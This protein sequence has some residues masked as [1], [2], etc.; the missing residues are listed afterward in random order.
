MVYLALG[1]ADCVEG[2]RRRGEATTRASPLD[3]SPRT[4]SVG[5]QLGSSVLSKPFNSRVQVQAVPIGIQDQLADPKFELP[6]SGSQSM[7]P[8]RRHA[9]T[10][11]RSASASSRSPSI[12][13]GARRRSL[14]VSPTA[15]LARVTLVSLAGLSEGIAAGPARRVGTDSPWSGCG[16]DWQRPQCGR[17]D[18]TCDRVTDRGR[19]EGRDRPQA[20]T[21]RP[22]QRR[23]SG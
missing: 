3:T 11:S 12:R 8:E 2:V 23:C 16:T 22:R 20:A 5:I 1:S 7:S 4:T 14:I 13:T 17:A 18:V 19:S 15:S 6:G 10:T 21:T 9:P